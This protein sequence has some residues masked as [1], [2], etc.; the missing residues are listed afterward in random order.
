MTHRSVFRRCFWKIL[1]VALLLTVSS[2]MARSENQTPANF[3]TVRHVPYDSSIRIGKHFKSLDI[4]APNSGK[5]HPI[6][7]W[8]HGGAWKIGDKRG[9]DQKPLAF[10]QHGYLLVS[11]NYRLHPKATYDEQA[12]DVAQAI[13][14]VHDHAQEYGGN[15]NQIFLMG[16]SA[17]AHLVALV[18]TN[19]AYLK[20]ESLSLKTIKGTILLDGAGYDIADRIK[21]AG[22]TGK[23]IYT[24]VFGEDEKIWKAASPLTYVR[25]NRSIPPFLILHVASRADS[26]RQS[27]RLAKKLKANQVDVSVVPAPGKTHMTINREIGQADDMPTQ[28]IFAF[29]NRITNAKKTRRTP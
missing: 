27:E 22:R 5:N 2:Q 20:Q 11:I 10:T 24:S 6:V 9:V 25:R 13:H 14:W 21:T 23:K 26:R 17:G 29:L 1:A 16:H 18:S 19:P 4:Y 28:K 7:V 8:V 12:Q 3:K 15:P